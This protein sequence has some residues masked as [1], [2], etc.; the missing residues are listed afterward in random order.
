MTVSA[1]FIGR[2][3]ARV[4]IWLVPVLVALLLA[5]Q[6][7][8]Q[9]QGL[10]LLM[11]VD[12]RQLRETSESSEEI[13]RARQVRVDFAYLTDPTTRSTRERLTLQ[14]FPDLSLV[15]ELR[16]TTATRNGWAWMGQVEGSPLSEVVLLISEDADGLRLSGSVVG[17]IDEMPAGHALRISRLPDSDVHLVTELDLE[18]LPACGV[19]ASFHPITDSYE[20]NRGAVGVNVGAIAPA[21]RSQQSTITLDIMVVYTPAALSAAGSQQQIEDEIENMILLSNTAFAN[22]DAG[23][24]LNLVHVAE[25]NYVEA[26]FSTD[27]GRLANPFD[28]HMDEIHALRREYAADLV[29]LITR[30]TTASVCGVGTLP[31]Q[32]DVSNIG[33]GFSITKYQCRAPSITFPHE[34]GHN[35][36]A[37]H[38]WYD[39]AAGTFKHSR[40]HA[41][42]DQGWRTIMSYSDKCQALG[43]P[44]PSILRFANPDV[45]QAG[46]PT[47]V[48]IGTELRCQTDDV[49]NPDC[50]ANLRATFQK[51]AAAVTQYL[52]SAAPTNVTFDQ[53]TVLEGV[54]ASIS[55]TN[56][57]AGKEPGEPDHDGNPGGNSVWYRWT[58]DVVGAT[59][60]EVSGA[61]YPFAL[62][63]YTGTD[64]DDLTQVYSG[65]ST[66]GRLFGFFSAVP[67]R[68]YHIA[69]DGIDEAVG[70]HGLSVYQLSLFIHGNSRFV[71]R[72]AITGLDGSLMATNLGAWFESPEPGH[73]GV[74]AA[75]RSVWYEWTAPEDAVMRFDTF[76]SDFDTRLAVYT[77][78]AVDEL[79]EVASNDDYINRVESQV[80]FFAE[81]GVS[82]KIAIDGYN[83]SMGN[84]QLNW[85]DAGQIF[86]D[87]FEP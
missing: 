60:I 66:N 33:L 47:G 77:G 64:V 43:Q 70:A 9:T 44:C 67:G 85:R 53:A 58:P 13:V 27:L 4:S 41:R 25:T 52:S 8:A 24:A 34:I 14:V 81:A 69:I 3:N 61:D 42:P 76:G 68:T 32:A 87:R 55:G 23:V 79:E 26:G 5:T 49:N 10:G 15:L 74:Q 37:G 86:K 56:A 6:A 12:E 28:G 57:D 84:I 18:R 35:L 71:D 30:P 31:N 19:R 75:R 72:V 7:S 11:P 54:Y 38:D 39:R 50:D 16:E 78:E 73:A 21:A 22:S 65:T 83:A 17:V 40:G 36:G 62:G 46:V 20:S 45:E 82:Y 59:T 48:P 63:I 2:C 29:A 80:E 1:V 51:T